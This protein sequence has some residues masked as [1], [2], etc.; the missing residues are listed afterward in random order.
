[1]VRIGSTFP[2]IYFYP[3]FRNIWDPFAILFDI[4]A[5]HCWF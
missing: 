3:L 5:P 1:M 4:P 2:P